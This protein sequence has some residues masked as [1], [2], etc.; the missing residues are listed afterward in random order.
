QIEDVF[1]TFGANF[2]FRPLEPASVYG[3][4]WGAT[5]GLIVGAADARKL[6]D[7]IPGVTQSYVP[8][9]MIMAGAHGPYGF[10]VQG[11]FLPSVNVGGFHAS[12][13]GGDVKWTFTEL[14]PNSPC[15]MAVRAG[16]SSTTINYS[17][18]VGGVADTLKYSTKTT[19]TSFSVSK[20][21]AATEPFAGV[22]FI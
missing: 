14:F 3:K 21:L 7:G 12:Q 6:T 8:N 19:D 10:G 4:N 9:A 17:Q 15:D 20:K 18:T 13:A 22:G 2:S 1:R 5:A 11:G 16:Y